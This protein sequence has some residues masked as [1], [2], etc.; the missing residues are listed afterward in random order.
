MYSIKINLKDLSRYMILED[1]VKLAQ[2]L[3]IQ[4][5]KINLFIC[6]SID[7][8]S[9]CVHINDMPDA[10]FQLFRFIKKSD[11][12]EIKQSVNIVTGDIE[13]H[14]FPLFDIIG[15]ELLSKYMTISDEDKNKNTK[16]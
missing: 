5:S 7:P 12:P 10:L 4:E 9:Y 15:T 3:K 8:Y 13:Y 14:L 6:N 2:L 16:E 1:S 11:L